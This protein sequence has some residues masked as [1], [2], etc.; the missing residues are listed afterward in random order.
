MS[1]DQGW[2]SYYEKLRDRPPRKTVIAALDAF[3]ERTEALADVRE[4]D[5]DRGGL[6]E[7]FAWTG[8]RDG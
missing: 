4:V 8:A 3:G 1:Q 5:T 2:A 6:N 7:N